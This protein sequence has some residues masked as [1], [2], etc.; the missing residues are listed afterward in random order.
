MDMKTAD[1]FSNRLFKIS[2]ENNCDV[3]KK[4]VHIFWQDF[5][6]WMY[7]EMKKSIKQEKTSMSK[8]LTNYQATAK[9]KRS[10]FFHPPRQRW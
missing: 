2:K 10:K 7:E 1:E 3:L 5:Q 4:E 6:G 9:S 8:I